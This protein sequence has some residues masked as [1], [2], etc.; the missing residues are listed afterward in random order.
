MRSSGKADRSNHGALRP[1]DRSLSR[2]S[3][4]GS[5]SPSSPSATTT[6]STIARKPMRPN[7]HPRRRRMTVSPTATTSS[8]CSMSPTATRTATPTPAI[9]RASTPRPTRVSSPT[10]ASSARS[11]TT[12]NLPKAG[13]P[14]FS[15]LCAGRRHPQREAPRGLYRDPAGQGEGRQGKE[16]QPTERR[17]GERSSRRF[18]CENFFDVRTFGAVMSTGINC[19]QVRGPVQL[20][21][22]R[23]IEPIVPLEIS[24]TRMAATN[25]AE[26]AERG[27]GDD[28]E[29]TREP[30]HG[31]QAHRALR[32]L[33]RPRLR[34]GQARR[35]HRLL[36]RPISFPLGR[37]RRTCSSTTARRRAARWRRAS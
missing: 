5:S 8:S 18:M 6:R 30:H 22:A 32:S 3:N 9:C 24:I 33:S 29:R 26:K 25:E 4:R 2:L 37:A 23:S 13:E 17:G 20:S 7:P 11:A 16:A 19:G 35:A 36:A 34:L 31:P 21:F 12:P 14:G 1:R 28:D 10:S 27:R 15:H